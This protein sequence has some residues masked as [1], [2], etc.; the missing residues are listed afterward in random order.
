[1][2]V[3]NVDLPLSDKDGIVEEGIQ[4][5]QA[6]YKR[7]GMPTTLSDA[8]IPEDKLRFMAE[9]SFVGERTHLGN[10]KKLYVDDVEKIY[11]LA[12]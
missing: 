10:F 1:M 12:L 4:R 9:N 3:W 5:L 8:N 2:R 11:R 7:I 6:F